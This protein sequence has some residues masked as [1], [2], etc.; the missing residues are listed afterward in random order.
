MNERE[1]FK[2]L[3]IETKSSICAMYDSGRKEHYG[4]IA[5]EIAVKKVKGKRV[6]GI[7]SIRS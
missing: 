6:S 3:R 4:L 2:I 1:A 7:R 5:K